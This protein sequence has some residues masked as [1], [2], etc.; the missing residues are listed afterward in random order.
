MTEKKKGIRAW[1]R[2]TFNGKPWNSIRTRKKTLAFAILFAVIYAIINLIMTY[3]GSTPDSTLTSEV[4][5]FCKWLVGTG[6]SITL[7]DKASDIVVGLRNADEESV[8]D[9]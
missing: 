9:E 8:I 5:S 6:T 2:R 7:A 3:I 1:W 4:F